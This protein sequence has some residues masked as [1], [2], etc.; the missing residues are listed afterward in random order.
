MTIDEARGSQ[1]SQRYLITSNASDAAAR[2]LGD[3]T[4]D[5]LFVSALG[6]SAFQMGLLNTLGSLAFVF[7]SVP[8]GHLVDK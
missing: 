3:I 4:I 7:A 8:A 5:L 6:A 1:G 2:G